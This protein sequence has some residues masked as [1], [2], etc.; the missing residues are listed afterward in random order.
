MVLP[1]LSKPVLV[2]LTGLVPPVMVTPLLLIVVLP[3][4]RLPELPKST[5]GSSVITNFLSPG[6]VLSMDATEIFLVS[7]LPVTVSPPNTFNNSPEAG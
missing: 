7:V 3:V 2:I 1:P 5:V 4:F 6:V